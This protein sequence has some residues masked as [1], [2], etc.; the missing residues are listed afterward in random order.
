MRVVNFLV[1]KA[2]REGEFP[3]IS[4]KDVKET[5]PSAAANTAFYDAYKIFSD[6]T[7]TGVKTII[8]SPYYALRQGFKVYEKRITY[9]LK[10]LGEFHKGVCAVEIDSEFY[11]NLK[12]TKLKRLDITEEKGE[13]YANIT[14]DLLSEPLQKPTKKKAS[15]INIPRESEHIIF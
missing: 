6:Y 4:T 11:S 15:W 1:E 14:Y 5:L 9:A 12:R 3:K 2:V 13:W 7:N 10:I 8:K